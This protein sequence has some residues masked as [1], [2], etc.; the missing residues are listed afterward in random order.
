[1]DLPDIFYFLAIFEW[2]VAAI[3]FC[4]VFLY[5]KRIYNLSRIYGQTV[6]IEAIVFVLSNLTAGGFNFW[7]GNGEITN[8]ID[9]RS[10]D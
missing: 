4:S 7:M 2:I 1:M 3:L 5:V 6:L 8:L 10:N 9:E